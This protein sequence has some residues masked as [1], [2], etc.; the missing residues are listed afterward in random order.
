VLTGLKHPLHHV[1]HIDALYSRHFGG[2]LPQQQHCRYEHRDDGNQ[3]SDD[4]GGNGNEVVCVQVVEREYA[5]WQ[6]EFAQA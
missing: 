2:S 4:I 5:R 3:Q 6:V 1:P